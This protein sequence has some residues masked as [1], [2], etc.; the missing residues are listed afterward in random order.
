V[1]RPKHHHYVSRGYQRKFADGEQIKLVWKHVDRVK[2]IGTRDAFA[3]TNYNAFESA[4]GLDDT[5]EHEWAKLEGFALPAI[6]RAAEGDRSPEVIERL[7][8]LVAIH[9]ARSG[10]T[11]RSVPAHHRHREPGA[12]SGVRERLEREEGIR[13]PL[14]PPAPTRRA[15]LVLRPTRL[16]KRVVMRFSLVRRWNPPTPR[17]RS[18]LAPPR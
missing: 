18:R 9:F 15:G 5:L 12:V 6:D 17:P 2:T 10:G 1:G 7:A 3:R 16:G 11:P 4:T 8:V 14:R 13:G